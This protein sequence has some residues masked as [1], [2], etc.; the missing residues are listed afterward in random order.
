MKEN[1]RNLILYS[2]EYNIEYGFIVELGYIVLNI[3]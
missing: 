3:L 2:V 1:D